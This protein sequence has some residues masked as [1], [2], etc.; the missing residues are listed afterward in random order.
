[1]SAIDLLRDQ[2]KQSDRNAPV[3]LRQE[4]CT[5]SAETA[6][7]I[8]RHYDKMKQIVDSLGGYSDE[9]SLT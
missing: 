9:W 4:P 8:I 3:Y 7:D 5:V 1:M 6:R 2:L